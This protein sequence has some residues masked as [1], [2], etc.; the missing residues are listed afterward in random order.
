MSKKYI[1][2]TCPLCG[3][4]YDSTEGRQDN[5]GRVM[6]PECYRKILQGVGNRR[7]R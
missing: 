7:W 1:E 6:C 4:K 3:K 5:L 2:A